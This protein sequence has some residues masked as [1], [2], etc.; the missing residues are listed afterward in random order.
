MR[1][2]TNIANIK[3]KSP[4]GT[5]DTVLTVNS[6]TELFYAQKAAFASEQA[7]SEEGD[8]CCHAE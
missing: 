4:I 3:E 2:S 1:E 5:V 6:Y 7:G 8:G